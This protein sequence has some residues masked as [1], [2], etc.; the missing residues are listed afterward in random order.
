MT[1]NPMTS[2]LDYDPVQVFW[3]LNL[4]PTS[5]SARIQWAGSR[6]EVDLG[7][8]SIKGKDGI[9]ERKYMMR[10]RKLKEEYWR[11]SKITWTKED[12][13]RCLRRQE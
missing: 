12:G 1:F 11:T 4:R 5:F 2:L 8:C 3:E 13:K 9:T 6:M 10:N 7:V